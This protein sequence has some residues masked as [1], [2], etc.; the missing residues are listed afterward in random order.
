MMKS[1]MWHL[2]FIKDTYM[3][4]LIGLFFLLKIILGIKEEDHQLI[5]LSNNL[6][7]Q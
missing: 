3:S 6:I 4:L 1:L 5:G 7:M 2:T